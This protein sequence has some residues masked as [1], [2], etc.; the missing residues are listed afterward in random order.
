V[1]LYN[2]SSVIF[3]ELVGSVIVDDLIG[4]VIFYDLIGSVIVDD[5]IGSV[6]FDD[7]IG[8]L[9]FDDLILHH[10]LYHN[11]F[12]PQKYFRP[13]KQKMKIKNRPDLYL[14]LKARHMKPRHMTK[15]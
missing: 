4:S 12:R 1:F 7:L 10:L 5:L 6:I 11:I 8:S 9:I 13:Q 14:L 3:D 15:L 2:Q